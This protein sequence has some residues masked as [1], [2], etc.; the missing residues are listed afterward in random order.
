M[1]SWYSSWFTGLPK[2]DFAVPSGIQRRFFSFLLRRTLGH[3]LKPGQLDLHQ[4]DSQL[5]SGTVQV[6]DLELN[7]QASPLL[8]FFCFVFCFLVFF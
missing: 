8:L 1:S 4:I 7:G 5:G 2:F 3:F 6:K